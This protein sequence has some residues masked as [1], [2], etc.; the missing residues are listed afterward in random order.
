MQGLRVLGMGYKKFPKDKV[1]ICQRGEVEEGLT[2][3]GLIVFVNPLKEDTAE[4]LERLRTAG[5]R[6]KMIS[7]DNSLTCAQTAKNASIVK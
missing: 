7:G 2:F 3:L 5:F 4:C 6:V 1:N